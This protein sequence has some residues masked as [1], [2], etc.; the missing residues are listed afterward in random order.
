MAEES[1]DELIRQLEM[2][3]VWEDTLLQQIIQARARESQQG[4]GTNGTD[5]EAVRYYI[6]DRVRITNP[7]CSLIGRP[8][9]DRDWVGTV[10]KITRKSVFLQTDNGINTNCAPEN[11][12]QRLENVNH[13][14][15][16]CHILQQFYLNFVTR[17]CQF[18]IFFLSK[19]WAQKSNTLL[20]T[21][22][23]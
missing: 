9:T 3:C 22:S 14:W 8:V 11:L 6:G 19:T 13:V 10:T 2:L 7:T 21:C 23:M 15:L 20:Q 12:H 18:V 17:V 5:R 1:V 4:Q 16:I